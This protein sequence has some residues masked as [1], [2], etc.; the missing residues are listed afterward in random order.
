MYR[1][2]DS[3]T[4]I[5]KE[6]ETA[7]GAADWDAADALATRIMG[8]DKVFLIGVGRVFLSLQAFAKRLGHIGVSAH[9]VGAVDEPALTPGDMLIVGSGSG[10]SIVPLAIAAKAK[11]LGAYIAHIG[12]NPNGAMRAYVDMFV[13]IPVGTKLGLP[14]EIRSE[15]I[16]SSLFEQSLLL[17]GDAVC[18]C[19]S[20]HSGRDIRTLW[21]RHA[22]LE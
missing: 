18:L 7:L 14:D 8:S 4:L 20:R 21:E 2:K 6:L 11:T 13:R 10:E 19:I 1:C 12:S 22:N 3:K 17:L 16:M 15:Q 9:C 5:L